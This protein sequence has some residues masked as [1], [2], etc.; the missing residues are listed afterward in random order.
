MNN[1]FGIITI[2][3]GLGNKDLF[4]FEN[5][6]LGTKKRESFWDEEGFNMTIP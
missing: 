2:C 4:L 3:K 6:N 1:N 5:K